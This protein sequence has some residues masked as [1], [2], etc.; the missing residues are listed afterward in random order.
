MARSNQNITGYFAGDTIEIELRINRDGVLMDLTDYEVEFILGPPSDPVVRKST[1]N[2]GV[3]RVQYDD[4]NALVVFEGGET[5][6][7]GGQTLTH[8]TYVT[9]PDGRRVTVET[10]P[11]HIQE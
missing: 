4:H 8:R 5:D 1:A 11:F 7:L 3:S 2:G 9:D 6:G 10:G